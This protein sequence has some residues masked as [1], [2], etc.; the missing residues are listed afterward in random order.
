VNGHNRCTPQSVLFTNDGSFF[1][2][3]KDVAAIP[4][5]LES[6]ENWEGLAN[7]LN[8]GSNVLKMDCAGERSRPACYRRKLVRYYCDSQVSGDPNNVTDDIA[9]ALDKM[10]LKRQAQ[11]LRN[12]QFGKWVGK[13]SS[14]LVCMPFVQCQS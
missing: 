5:E 14:P 12:L 4:N 13:H 3:E 9:K 1:L 2:S 6:V 10:N 7:W 11:R 8:V